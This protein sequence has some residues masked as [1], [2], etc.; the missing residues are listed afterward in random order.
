MGGEVVRNTVKTR[1]GREGRVGAPR[2]HNVKGKFGVGEKAVPKVRGKVGMGGGEGGDEVVLC[3]PH[4]FL[5]RVGPVHLWGNKL[6]R[7]PL[8]EKILSAL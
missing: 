7:Q 4:R 8:R 1:P 2:A 3:C 5:C 6:H